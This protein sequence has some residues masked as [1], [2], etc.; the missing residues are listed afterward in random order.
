[1]YPNSHR[2]TQ[3]QPVLRLK[4]RKFFIKQ[5]KRTREWKLVLKGL[6]IGSSQT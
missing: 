6:I 4:H 2:A 1:M 3:P 5:K